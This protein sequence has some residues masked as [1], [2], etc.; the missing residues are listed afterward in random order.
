MDFKREFK[1][2]VPALVGFLFFAVLPAVRTS[3]YQL[4]IASNTIIWALFAM[5]F[6]MLFGM[7]G[8][9]SFGQALYFGLGG[10]FVGLLVCHLGAGWFVPAVFLGV[11]GAG[12]LSLI[13]GPMVLRLTGVYFTILTLAF[14]QLGWGIVVKW[15]DFTNGDDGI[16]GIIP[17]GVLGNKVTYYYFCFFL[18]SLSLWL[19]WRISL[20]PFGLILRCVRQNPD[21][22]RFLGRRVKRNQLRIYV[23][24]SMFTALAGALMAGVDNS[25]STEMWHWT[26]SGEV[27]LMCILGG[28]GQFYGPFA[29][30]VLMI[31]IEDMVGA[32]TEMWSMVIGIIMLVMV[33]AF[34]KGVVGEFANLAAR[35]TKKSGGM[36][37]G[38][39]TNTRS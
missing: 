9:L 35:L 37:V 30:A 13:V 28:I 26:T 31:L 17:P 2:L 7:T 20:S 19:L 15:Y 25:V 18:V 36:E 11:L 39:G 23:L 34:P 27:I 1:T 3:D 33:L 22:V 5:S 16:Q 38:L 32:R 29:G 21:R 6:N 8:M 4:T 24:S 10:Y 14:A 12:A